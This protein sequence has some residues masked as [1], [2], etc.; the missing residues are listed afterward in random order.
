MERKNSDGAAHVSSVPVE[1]VYAMVGKSAW[2][3]F[4]VPKCACDAVRNGEQ[5]AFLL[6]ASL[7]LSERN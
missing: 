1:V 2:W 3:P 4:V 6:M 7:G 5:P